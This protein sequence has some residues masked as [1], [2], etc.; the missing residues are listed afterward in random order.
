M[1]AANAKNLQEWLRLEPSIAKALAQEFKNAR[2][3][4]DAVDRALD[5]ANVAIS[6]F[7]VEPINGD[8]HVD[9]YYFDIVALYV[10]TGDT[11]NGTV[12][13][14]TDRE[15]FLVTTMGDWVEQNERKYRIR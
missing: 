12:L 9:N 1:P 13:Y 7:G 5:N 4:H 6:G 2:G 11:Y 14:E 15:R 8:Y 3:D 10:N